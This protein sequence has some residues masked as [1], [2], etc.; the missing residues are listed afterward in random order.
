MMKWF[1]NY[2]TPFTEK[3]SISQVV[4]APETEVYLNATTKSFPLNEETST[5]PEL[6]N[7]AK[8][9]KSVSKFGVFLTQ[10]VVATLP[11]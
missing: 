4:E 5:L 6:T 8:F 2:F 7:P 10:V 11:V 3:L 1:F 9:A